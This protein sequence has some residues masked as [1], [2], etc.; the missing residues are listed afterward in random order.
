MLNTKY[1]AFADVYKIYEGND[2]N[3]TYEAL[4]KLKI[5]ILK[6][7]TTQLKNKKI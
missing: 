7:L 3:K 4:S 1:F 5:E 6:L 2:F